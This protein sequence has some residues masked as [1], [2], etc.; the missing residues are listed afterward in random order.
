MRRFRI[1][2]PG[3]L[4]IAL[5]PRATLIRDLTGYWIAPHPDSRAKVITAQFY[6]ARDRS[7]RDLGTTLYRRHLFDVRNLVTLKHLFE[8]VKHLEFLPNSAYAFPVTR[9]SWHG[10]EALPS[11]EFPRDS[12]LLVYYL[13]PSRQW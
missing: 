7:Q 6:L 10:R 1:D 3:L 13:D 9:T 11:G 2:R 12:L 8:P 5:H 4:R